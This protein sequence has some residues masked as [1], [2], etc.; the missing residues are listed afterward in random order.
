MS[1]PTW[2]SGQMTPNGFNGMISTINNLPPQQYHHVREQMV[3]A[4]ERLKELEKQVPVITAVEV[5]NKIY[6]NNMVAKCF[7]IL[8]K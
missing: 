1:S 6:L 3:A 2:A 5:T 7:K 4:L 8:T